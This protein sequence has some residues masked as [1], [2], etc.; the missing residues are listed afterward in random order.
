MADNLGI[1]DV[2]I[3]VSVGGMAQYKQDIQ[4][5]LLTETRAQ[6]E[7]MS[8]LEAALAKGWQGVSH[9]RFLASFKATTQDL[10]T[11]MEL[12]YNDLMSRLE[13]LEA[14]YFNQ[15]ENLVQE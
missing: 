15:D 12:E 2:S 13:E 14:Y 1:G 10:A 3:G 11:E 5:H 4:A 8:E 9:D 6:L 7:E